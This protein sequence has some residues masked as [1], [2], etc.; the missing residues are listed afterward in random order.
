MTTTVSLWSDALA[1]LHAREM[2]QKDNL[3][4]AFWGA[5]VLQAAGVTAW[6]GEPVDQD[7]VALHAGTVLPVGDPVDAVPPGASPRTD[8]RLALSTAPESASAGTAAA[9]VRRA[10]ELVSEGRLAVVPV[11]G[12]WSAA[13]VVDL[14]DAAEETQA[15]AVLV[16]NLRTGRLWGSRPP[17]ALVLAH[18]AGRPV[19]PPPPDWDVGHFVTL[20]SRLRGRGG[21]LV[22][23]RDTYPVLGW[24]GYHVQPP[25]AVAEALARGD[26]HE[27]G[28][29]CAVPAPAA[30]EL[31]RALSARGFDL[32]DWDNGT[33]DHMGGG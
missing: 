25:E 22:V 4:G 10:L 15:G 11:A 6:N 13:S 19:D 17:A 26:G 14:I 21:S 9:A 1:A 24:G 23:V 16:A 29:L 12:P 28:V 3:C 18:L 20:A 5:L 31:R 2:P 8:Y 33:P 32:R 27:G 30:E 7:L